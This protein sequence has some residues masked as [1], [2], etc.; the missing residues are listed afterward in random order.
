MSEF[1]SYRVDQDT[2]VNCLRLV[3]TYCGDLMRAGGGALRGE[4]LH[5][6]T[7]LSE[8]GRAEILKLRSEGYSHACIAREV[9]I[10][11]GTV[12]KVLRQAGLTRPR[13]QQLM[14]RRFIA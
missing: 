4:Q 6:G 5:S 1:F 7:R 3:A 13:G 14:G 10:S 12:S 9:R 11:K 8:K 2:A